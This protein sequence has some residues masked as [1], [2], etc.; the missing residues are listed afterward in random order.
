MY[1][2]SLKPKSVHLLSA[3]LFCQAAHSD[4]VA[5]Q[6]ASG[7]SPSLCLCRCRWNGSY[8]FPSWTHLR[9]T[10]LGALREASHLSC[11]RHHVQDSAVGLLLLGKNSRLLPFAFKA[12]HGLAQTC[13]QPAL[14]PAFTATSWLLK[15]LRLSP[16]LGL[17][18]CY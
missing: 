4:R 7:S 11:Q 8:L 5:L 18:S 17:D 3:V 6:K 15:H 9:A 1:Y 12:L 13:Q 14:L 16:A 2:Y 10:T